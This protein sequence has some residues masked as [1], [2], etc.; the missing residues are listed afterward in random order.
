MAIFQAIFRREDDGL[1]GEAV[2]ERALRRAL[3]AGL[4]CGAVGFGAVFA[5]GLGFAH[6]RHFKSPRWIR[7]AGRWRAEQGAKGKRLGGKE[8]ERREAS[9]WARG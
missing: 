2:A 9:H 6:R 8:I 4:G 3:F 5:G 7:V 1:A